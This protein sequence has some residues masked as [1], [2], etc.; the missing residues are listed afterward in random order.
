ME[1]LRSFSFCKEAEEFGVEV[2]RGV[3][4]EQLR[5]SRLRVE[6]LRSRGRS[7]VA[8]FLEEVYGKRKEKPLVI[9]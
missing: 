3:A 8:F 2:L 6:T 1:V 7:P 4:G 5:S 9:Y